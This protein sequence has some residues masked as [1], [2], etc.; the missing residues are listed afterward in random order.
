MEEI[1][2]NVL[3]RLLVEHIPL[4]DVSSV[5]L[6]NALDVGERSLT[7]VGSSAFE[8]IV[9][10]FGHLGSVADQVVDIL[11]EGRTVLDHLPH[12]RVTAQLHFG[13]GQPVEALL[14]QLAPLRAFPLRPLHRVFEDDGVKVFSQ[15]LA[16]A[17]AIVLAEHVPDADGGAEEEFVGLQLEAHFDTG[18]RLAH[19]VVDPHGDG[20]GAVLGNLFVEERF[21]LFV[22]PGIFEPRRRKQGHCERQEDRAE[23]H[24]RGISL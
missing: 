21:A 6:S 11:R 16:V 20:L 10:D 23:F 13:V 9:G 24:R 8:R 15:Q 22:Q 14:Q 2:Q 7:D 4:D 1:G 19:A 12:H 3:V 5:G 17:F 18:R